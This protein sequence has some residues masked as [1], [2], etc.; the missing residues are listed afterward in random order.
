MGLLDNI[1]L[2]FG[3]KHEQ[4]TQGAM[5]RWVIG[6]FADA[7]DAEIALNNLDEAGYEPS[8]ISAI[9]NE[10]KRTHSLTDVQ[11]ALSQVSV[12]QLPA[13]LVALGLP[14]AES[15]SYGQRVAA[16]AVLLAIAAPA[17]SED[18]AKEILTDQKAEM[19]QAL[20]GTTSA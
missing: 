3:P 7:S 2:R 17:G 11:G 9:T 10:V 8:T 13:R 15:T 16:G 5:G 14:A 18:A 4:P 6:V 19:A 12:D 1:K 20:P